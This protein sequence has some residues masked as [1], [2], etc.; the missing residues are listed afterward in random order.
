[1]ELESIRWL[2][3]NADNRRIVGPTLPG[4]DH[5]FHTGLHGEG[6]DVLA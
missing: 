6:W 5:V 3:D 2:I 4:G 1:M